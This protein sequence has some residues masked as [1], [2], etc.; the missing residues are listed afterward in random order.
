MKCLLNIPRI[1]VNYYR[2]RSPVRQF[3][4]VSTEVNQL[5]GDL[6]RKFQNVGIEETESRLSA[7]FI[8]AHVM[9]KKMFYQVS[10]S[11]KIPETQLKEIKDLAK[12]RSERVPLQYVLGEWDFCEF[13]VK[14]APPVLIP[15]P[16]TEELVQFVLQDMAQHEISKKFLEVGCG[17]G[18]VTLCLLSKLPWMRAVA[19]DISKDA[20]NLTIENLSRYHV[21]KRASVLNRDF[22]SPETIQLISE[23]GLFD[24][25]ISNPP[26]IPTAHLDDLDPEVKKYE[27]RLALDGG[28]DGLD[29]VRHLIAV[30]PLLLKKEGKLWLETGLEQHHLIENAINNNSDNELRYIKSMK[31]FTNRERFCLVQK[32]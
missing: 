16:E 26:Y 5:C 17:S 3:R 13:T 10:K 19:C 11:A 6:T 21:D 24:F 18:A 12:K 2:K 14:L 22:K 31:D 4:S 29:F 20:C 28:Q 9:G 30:S 27:D 32:V 1:S 7:E 23:L 8:I 25:I 15:R